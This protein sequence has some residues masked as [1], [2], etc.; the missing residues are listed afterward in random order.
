MFPMDP[1]PLFWIHLKVDHPFT[2]EGVLFFPKMNPNKPFNESNIR[3]YNKQVFVSNQVKDIVPEFLSL[4]KGCIDSSD[5]PLNV[6]RSSLQGDPNIKKISNYVIKKVAESLKKLFNNDRAR[7]E[8]IW[9]DIALFMKYGCI[10]D[11]KFDE[12]MRPMVIKLMIR[13][14]KP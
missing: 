6:S 9:E 1:T 8:T 4:L 5:I 13:T 2:L 12:M 3:L 14:L 11:N 7:F 10:S